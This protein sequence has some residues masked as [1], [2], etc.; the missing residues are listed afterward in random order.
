MRADTP[1]LSPEPISPLSPSPYTLAQALSPE[2]LVPNPEPRAPWFLALHEA[3]SVCPCRLV[4]PC[5]SVALA[6]LFARLWP[7]GPISQLPYADILEYPNPDAPWLTKLVREA[8]NGG[9]ADQADRGGG[10]GS[11]RDGRS[12]LINQGSYSYSYLYLF[13]FTFICG[14][15]HS[16]PH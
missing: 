8:R 3:A 10:G 1:T 16:R 7:M 5:V 6:L 13:T 12:H 11:G 9:E 14:Q 15:V 2:S 4:V